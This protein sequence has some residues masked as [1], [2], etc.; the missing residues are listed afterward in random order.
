MTEEFGF[1]SAHPGVI[2]SVWADGSSHT[3]RMTANLEILNS[4]GKRADGATY[5]LDDL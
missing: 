2:T 5:S 4:L 1:G 3:I